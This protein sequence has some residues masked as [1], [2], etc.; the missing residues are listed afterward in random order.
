[1]L[2]ERGT[3]V[4]GLGVVIF[5][6]G[7][8]IFSTFLGNRIIDGEQSKPVTRDTR[9]RAASVSKMFTA[10][11]ILQL[12]ELGVLD[13]DEDVGRY[14][15][16]RLRNPNFPQK[17]ITVRM[18]A[19]HTSSLRD[20]KIYSAPPDCELEEFFSSSGRFFEGGAHF[21]PSCEEPGEYF[22]YSN[23]NY[24]VLGTII[25]RVTGERFDLY[26]KKHLFKQLEMKADYVPGNFEHR[27][28]EMLGATYQK[29]NPRG[30][31][32]ER[33][34]WFGKSD[35]YRGVQPSKETL[36]LQNPY[37]ET[38]QSTYSLQNY[39]VGTNATIF[40]PQGG[41]RISFDEMSRTLEMLLDGGEFRG[42]RILSRNSIDMLLTPQWTFDPTIQNGNTYD[43]ALLSYGFG[44][45][46]IEFR[47]RTWLGH[48]GEAF[49]MLSGLF[50][51]PIARDGFAY[52]INGTAIDVENDPRARGIFSS[53]YI[54][55]EQMLDAID[56]FQ[57]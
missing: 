46:P 13:P 27:E 43:G 40:S 56:E 22:H 20:G 7:S 26:Q 14:L 51:D 17:K 53:N 4:P 31:W 33:G 16:F 50:F 45:H 11:S 28:F 8:E 5:K 55:E 37:D 41:L 3:K 57:G 34:R 12:I 47:G 49:G 10:M 48:S 1:M 38:F 35:D 21:A 9:F 25:E 42:H 24:G 2:G 36:A 52:M 6:D 39:R 54:W 29:K 18:L 44:T 32:D 19:A 23:L 30:E 15:N